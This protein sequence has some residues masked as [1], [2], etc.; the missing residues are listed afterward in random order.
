MWA[1]GQSYQLVTLT[2]YWVKLKLALVASLLLGFL[3]H[4]GKESSSFLCGAA[5]QRSK[6]Q[7]GGKKQ[8]K[9]S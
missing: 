4:A 5:G 8:G 2:R 1:A 7:G 6:W 3:H 9:G